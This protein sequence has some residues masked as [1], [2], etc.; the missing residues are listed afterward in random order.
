MHGLQ[1]QNKLDGFEGNENSRRRGVVLIEQ[2]TLREYS[3][4]EERRP[5]TTNNKCGMTHG[6]LE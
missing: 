3:I 6:C 1:K 5:K 2:A 4:S